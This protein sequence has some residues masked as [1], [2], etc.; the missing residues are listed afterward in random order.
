MRDRNDKC[1][2]GARETRRRPTRQHQL[3]SNASI[4]FNDFY[5]SMVL[6]F[7]L[8]AH[9]KIFYSLYQCQFTGHAH[10][11]YYIVFF[12]LLFMAACLFLL[13]F[14]YLSI[15]FLF[16]TMTTGWCKPSDKLIKNKSIF[17]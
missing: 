3:Y 16:H 17:L 1:K 10:F 15:L 6:L 7:L 12:F 13:I 14:F 8:V 2:G 9:D 5:D 11:I 4:V